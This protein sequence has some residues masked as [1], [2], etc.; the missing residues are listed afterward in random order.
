M[1]VWEAHIKKI[2]SQNLIIYPQLSKQTNNEH[3]HTHTKFCCCQRTLKALIFNLWAHIQKNYINVKWT[4]E[5]FQLK[6]SHSHFEIIKH[7]LIECKFMIMALQISLY[8][9]NISNIGYYF[10]CAKQIF[11]NK[12]NKNDDAADTVKV[13]QAD[14]H[15]FDRERALIALCE[16]LIVLSSLCK[17]YFHELSI[18]LLL[19]W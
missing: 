18:S 12:N 7:C 3:S 13:T 15:F 4:I 14:M 16:I 9:Y 5:Y 8:F 1:C 17:F 2:K 11:T 19:C 6:S 10:T